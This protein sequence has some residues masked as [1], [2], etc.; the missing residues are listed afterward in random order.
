MGKVSTSGL[1]WATRQGGKVCVIQPHSE[2]YFT[3]SDSTSALCFLLC[4]F[5]LFSS[6]SFSFFRFSLLF[7]CYSCSLSFIFFLTWFLRS[8]RFC[9]ILVLSTLFNNIFLDLFV[10]DLFLL[11]FFYFIFTNM[12]FFDLCASVLFLFSFFSFPLSLLSNLCV[13]LLIK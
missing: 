8:L 6:T 13:F 12:I 5:P 1:H 3:L 11:S 2:L 4:R 9:L 10:S 7:L